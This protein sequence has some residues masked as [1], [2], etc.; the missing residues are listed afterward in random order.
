MHVLAFP[1]RRSLA[2]RT[3]SFEVIAPKA[4]F[5]AIKHARW[6]IRCSG[7]LPFHSLRYVS[8]RP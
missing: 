2:A 1:V 4:R 8:P 6:S 5:P 7:D 3:G